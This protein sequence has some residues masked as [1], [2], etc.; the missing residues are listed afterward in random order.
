MLFFGPGSHLGQHV[1]FRVSLGSSCLWRLLSLSLLFLTLILWGGL[2]RCLGE[3]PSIW[4]LWGFWHAYTRVLGTF[5]K[6]Y[7]KGYRPLASHHIR[8]TWYGMTL[9]GMITLTNWFRW[10]LPDFSTIALLSPLSILC[11]LKPITKSSS[12]SWG[13]GWC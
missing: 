11:P 12:Y 8:G 5:W 3:C 9:L 10:S 1:A 6:E 7:I 4:L 2:V 13:Q